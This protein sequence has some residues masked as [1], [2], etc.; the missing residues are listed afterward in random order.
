M[1]L[2]NFKRERVYWCRFFY[3]PGSHAFTHESDN[4]DPG[5]TKNYY[6]AY[7]YQI[8]TKNMLVLLSF[9]TS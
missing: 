8:G 9:Q 1:N 4:E 7:L 2:I 6:A 3:M 5:G